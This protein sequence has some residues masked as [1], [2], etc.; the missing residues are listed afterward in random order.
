M[1]RLGAYKIDLKGQEEAVASY[2]WLV[3]SDFFAALDV[4]DVRNGHVAVDLSVA[5]ASGEYDLTFNLKGT[6]AVP[7]D[8]CLD[9]MDIDI[10]TDGDLKVR[11]GA[12]FADDGDVVVVP[13]LEGTINVSWYIYEFISLAIPL[14]HVHAPGKCNKEMS[15]QLDKHTVSDID[16]GDADGQI[17]SRW[18]ELEK[19][20]FEEEL[21]ND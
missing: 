7:C 6:V 10:D 11:L 19:L 14:K 4:E 16:G 8:R 2:R 3:D 5:K 1:G 17:D 20:N 13:E 12:D 15:E 18:A 21:N 9:D